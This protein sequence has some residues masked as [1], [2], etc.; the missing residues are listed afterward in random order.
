MLSSRALQVFI[1]ALLLAGIPG[2]LGYFGAWAWWF[3]LAAH[4]RLQYAAAL[5]LALGLAAAARRWRLALAAALL[6]APNLVTIAQLMMAR[7]PEVDGP[8]LHLAHFN[9]LT[10]NRQHAEVSAWIAGSGA[11]LVSLQEVD[12]RWAAVLAD[13]PGYH[14]VHAMPR[15]DNFG[16]ALLA[17]DDATSLVGAV[18]SLKLA[19]MPALALELHHA[20]RPLALL[21]LHTLPPMSQPY[22]ETRNAQLAAAAT[23]ARAQRARGFAP[24][25]LGDFNA[26]PF[27]IALAPLIA[28]D[29]H[30]SL[31][32][33]NVWTAGSWPDL[34]WP[35][36]I[37][38]DH[39]W[40]DA[41]LA[42]SAR[43]I[44]PA[45]GSDHR[46]LR[47]DLRWAR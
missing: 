4:F 24:V 12:E 21:S 20:E 22:T 45:L 41:R 29:L 27:S 30:D 47:L 42:S 23:W 1:I 10:S 44:G 25:I 9:L 15:A 34:P 26:T 13:V 28:A 19:G 17:R 35:L 11:A 46:P 33:G 7:S 8:P 6:L 40:H 16:L 14:L 32:A 18:H 3:D 5:L 39:C 31:A 37:A 43:T 38:I 2:L 36:R